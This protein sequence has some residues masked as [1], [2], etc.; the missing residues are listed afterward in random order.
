MNYIISTDKLLAEI[1]RLLKCT[2]S[3]RGEAVADGSRQTLYWIKDFIV[4]HQ[5]QEPKDIYKPSE[6]QI[7]AL[8]CAE[9]WY[10]DNMGCNIFL[11]Q[12]LCDLKKL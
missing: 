7:E 4:S 1:E 9:R 8:E 10:S 3:H 12:L 6:E 5:Y 11:Y 2:E